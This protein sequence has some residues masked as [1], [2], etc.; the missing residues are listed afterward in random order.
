M[1]KEKISTG[2]HYHVFNR[3]NNKQEI[4]MEDCD[5]V[6]FLF[7]ILHLQSPKTFTNISRPV[8]FFVRHSVFNT[9]Q[10]DEEE[11]LKDRNVELVSFSLM[12]NHFHLIIREV[13]E[14]GISKYMQRI[15]NAYTKYINTKYQK[16]GH[17]FQGPFKVVRVEDNEQLL[18]LSAYVHRN[19]RELSGI[20]DKEHEY[21]W[22]SFQDYINKNRWGRLIAPEIILD[23]FSN[24]QKY[25]EFV[26]ESGTKLSEDE[27]LIDAQNC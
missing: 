7:L 24:G 15:L 18:H 25:K 10:K 5:W 4:F 12:P 8:A 16:T 1:R 17:L 26:D 6:R 2:E 9:S 20:K 23:Q 14:G 21:T 13:S 22:S 27:L 11:I 3:G 19:P